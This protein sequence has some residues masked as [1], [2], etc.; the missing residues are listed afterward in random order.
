ML[1]DVGHRL[2]NM[3]HL[4][5]LI[6]SL[7][8]PS[9]VSS[10]AYDTSYLLRFNL[11]L[12]ETVAQSAIKW[13][14]NNQHSDGSWGSIAYHT[15]DRV[16]CTLATIIALNSINDDNQYRQ[17]INKGISF[18]N[19]AVYQ[20]G[21]E[22]MDTIGFPVI[23]SHLAKQAEYLIAIPEEILP[24]KQYNYKL[25]GLS[26]DELKW[27]FS[28]LYHS[29]EIVLAQSQN[30]FDHLNPDDNGC[31]GASPAATIVWANQSVDTG[32][33]VSYINQL[34]ERQGD[35]GLPPVDFINIF[36]I[37]WT[38][39]NLRLAGIIKPDMPGV[40][41]VLDQLWEIWLHNDHSGVAFS[42][43]FAVPDLDETSVA[44]SLLRWANYPARTSAFEQFEGDDY[45]YCY[46]GE[47][48]PSLSANIRFLA[49]L[50]YATDHP[51]IERWRNKAKN[52]LRKWYKN[53]YWFDKWHSSPYY[54]TASSV[55]MLDGILDELL[56]DMI[57]WIL[58]TQ[59][60]D[61]GW[62]HFGFSTLEETSYCVQALAHWHMKTNI[63]KTSIRHGLQYLENAPEVYPPM[64]IG[65]CLY[66]PY[67]V[68]RSSILSAKH[69]AMCIDES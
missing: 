52:S 36:E 45:F 5:S 50:E 22:E 63:D 13:L 41:N 31:I 49:A 51:D 67:K 6:Q 1:S 38:L 37:C 56:P 39:N 4:D 32:Q 18:L 57:N 34:I 40:R 54:L 69:T 53:P 65:K 17:A 28:T 62:G 47:I 7:I 15:H 68:V 23:F 20:L 35:G 60:V 21:Q 9:Q 27:K 30:S 29:I 55:W 12:P 8:Q 14:K 64:W 42:S 24:L 66:T 46:P 59:N 11:N 58:E 33:S 43:S 61:G 2:L 48:D 44:Y 10:G 25:Q 26:Q 3:S 16:I 19:N